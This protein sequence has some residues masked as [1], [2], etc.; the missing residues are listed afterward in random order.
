MPSTPASPSTAVPPRLEWR[1]DSLYL[2]DQTRLPLEIVVERQA[3][4][5]QV[6]ES[7]RALK[8]RGAPAIGVAGAYGLCVAM[9]AG[10]A[11]SVESFRARLAEQ[12]AY[13]ASARPTAV[14]LQWAL[15]RLLARLARDE[16]AR[17]ANALY[18]ALVD[19]A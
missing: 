13:L 8:V 2:L 12:A 6:W 1:D 10:R 19:E 4:V 16:G 11:G 5:E 18:E 3:S 17:E 9:Q 7:I 15:Q 14:N